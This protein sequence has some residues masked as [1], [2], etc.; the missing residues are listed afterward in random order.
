MAVSGTYTFELE[1]DDIVEAAYRKV[2]IPYV[3]QDQA[4]IGRQLLNLIFSDWANDQVHLWSLSYVTQTLSSGTASYTLNASYID[5]IEAAL[6]D[7]DG[8]D[9]ELKR[10]SHAQ[11]MAIVDK[12]AEG[13]PINYVIERTRTGVVMKVWP[14]QTS[15]YTAQL[16]VVKW[17][18]DVTLATQ[19]VGT[20]RRFYPS[21]ILRLAYEIALE[22]KAKIV[23]G[24]DGKM[25]EVNGTT[26]EERQELWQQYTVAFQKAKDEDRDRADFKIFPARR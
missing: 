6:R 1:V 19:N 13:P 15:T 26:A 21:L 11:Y 16:Y 7:S 9:R 18:D 10:L 22:N 5:V 24:Q 3:G 4:R 20:V 12:D 14:V 23:I 8:N 2:G 17:A 25:K